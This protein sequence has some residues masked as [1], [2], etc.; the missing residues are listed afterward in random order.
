MLSSAILSGGFLVLIGLF[1]IYFL[2]RGYNSYTRKKLVEELADEWGKES[3]AYRNFDKIGTYSSYFEEATEG[4]RLNKQSFED[5]N[6]DDVYCK[7]DRCKTKIGQQ[8]LY[9][10]IRNPTN[11]L[12]T[13][14]KRNDI[15]DFFQKHNDV[16]TEVLIL[17]V[18]LNKSLTY[19]IPN[20][21]F[22]WKLSSTTNMFL[23]RILSIA[24]ILILGLCLFVSKSFLLLLALSFFINL[25][26]H[27][28]NKSRVEHFISP[29]SQIPFLRK[30][31]I[32]LLRVDAFF[33]NDEVVE[34]LI[35]H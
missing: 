18:Q 7:V 31:T 17:L 10:M 4:S 33:A 14:G 8:V 32:S 6:L 24:P 30:Y 35:I 19:S 5:L 29:F 11:D 20:I 28:K 3:M 21:I 16:R 25:I 15:I 34:R 13:L 12:S 23:I 22:N 26:F 2:F 1:G 9:S 27:Y